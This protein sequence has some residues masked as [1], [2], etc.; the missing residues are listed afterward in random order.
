MC[1]ALTKQGTACKK[2]AVCFCAIHHSQCAIPL[3]PALDG[4]PPSC[5]IHIYVTICDT[6]ETM[7]IRLNRMKRIVNG[8]PGRYNIRLSFI[9]IAEL[10]KL[11]SKLCA[12]DDS[13]QGLTDTVASKLDAV[14]ELTAYTEDFRRKCSRSHREAA[15]NRVCAFYFK[16][17]ED[18]CDDVIEKVLEY[19]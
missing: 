14:P 17:C 2:Y 7:Y 4:W 12:N 10:L 18:L 9:A 1:R 5:S 15:R 3:Y 16:R 6:V 11:N 13:L 8:V 19:V